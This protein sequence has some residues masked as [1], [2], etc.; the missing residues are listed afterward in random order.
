MSARLLV[1]AL[2]AL[3]LPTASAAAEPAGLAKPPAPL[4][5]QSW[6]LPEHM[7]WSDYRPIPGFNWAHDD[8]QP[9]KKLR[10]ALVLGD[11]PDRE[12]LVSRPGGSGP[13]GTP[14]AGGSLAKAKAA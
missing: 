6:V 13:V 2:A 8:N 1:S 14:R 4:D 7:A 9:P 12:S 3:A 11:F 10:A 5:P